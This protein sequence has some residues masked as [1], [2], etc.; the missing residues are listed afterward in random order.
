VDGEF[1]FNVGAIEIEVT[2]YGTKLQGST[3]VGVQSE[4]KKSWF[5]LVEEDEAASRATRSAPISA[6]ADIFASSDSAENLAAAAKVLSMGAATPAVLPATAELES[7]GAA[8]SEGSSPKKTA[9]APPLRPSQMLRLWQYTVCHLALWMIMRV[10][11]VL[12]WTAAVFQ[13]NH[14][15]LSFPWILPF[16]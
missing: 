8:A 2:P 9:T 10:M 3:E 1:V 6:A 11:S 13:M 5:Q 12:L 7:V 14:L 4:P 15:G 16:L